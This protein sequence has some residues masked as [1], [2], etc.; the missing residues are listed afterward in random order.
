MN[1]KRI[2]EGS[3]WVLE[4]LP[5]EIYKLDV[6]EVL[7]GF[8]VRVENSV[9]KDPDSGDFLKL[10]VIKIS[11][12][13]PDSGENVIRKIPGTKNLDK[14]FSLRKPGDRV[15]IVRLKDIPMPA[16]KKPMQRYEVFVWKAGSDI[17]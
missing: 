12:K 15:K 14:W 9:F 8:F 10:Y 1:Q 11:K 7:I 13:D 17:L 3:G 4:P 16:P 6:N 5:S 2:N